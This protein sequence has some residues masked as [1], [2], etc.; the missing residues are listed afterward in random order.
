M[1]GPDA[2]TAAAWWGDRAMPVNLTGYPN[3][4]GISGR[5]EGAVLV[6]SILVSTFESNAVVQSGANLAGS[7][8]RSSP[9]ARFQC[10]YDQH[11]ELF[12]GSQSELCLTLFCA[13]TLTDSS[14]C[15]RIVVSAFPPAPSDVVVASQLAAAA[16]E[17]HCDQKQAYA[18]DIVGL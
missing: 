18:L 2:S 11:F 13:C 10:P 6:W 12:T 15:R 9:L 7:R 3:D 14:S 16:D 1:D 8:I 4:G 5:K 17:I